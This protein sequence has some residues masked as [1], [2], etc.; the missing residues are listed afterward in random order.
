MANGGRLATNA[1]ELRLAL[2]RDCE[3]RAFVTVETTERWERRLNI[4]KRLVFSFHR[5]AIPLLD[6]LSDKAP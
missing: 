6:I 2:K 4:S 1:S 3:H 5:P